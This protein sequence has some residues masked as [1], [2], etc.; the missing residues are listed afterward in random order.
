MPT[1]ELKCNKKYTGIKEINRVEGKVKFT[2]KG[3]CQFASFHL[4]DTDG[5]EPPLGF[6]GP[7]PTNGQGKI[8]EYDYD[9]T[10]IPAEGYFFYYTLK[11]KTASSVVTVTSTITVS[12]GVTVNTLPHI[13]AGDGS[14]VIKNR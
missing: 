1:F 3:G 2:L 11:S 5:D 13:T 12:R 7:H 9:G 14:G 4:V 6:N 8:I 10:E